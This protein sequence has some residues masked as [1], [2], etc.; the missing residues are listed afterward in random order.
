MIDR[1][2]ILVLGL[3]AS[4]QVFAGSPFYMTIE[5]SYRSD[6]SPE[7]RIDARRD[8]PMI[9]RVLKAEHIDSFL[10]GQFPVS[11]AYEEPK[12]TLNPGHH[13]ARG[14]NRWQWPLEKIRRLFREDFRNQ[15]G[16]VFDRP[17]QPR[18]QKPIAPVPPILT[19]RPPDG[20]TVIRE[21]RLSPAG[22]GEQG[23]ADDPFADLWTRSPQ[24]G[25]G[26]NL[27]TEYDDYGRYQDRTL[28]LE[29]LPPGLYLIQGIQG[30]AEG[31][32]LLQVT[33]L[34]VE[35]LQSP[36]DLIVHAI[37]RQGQPLSGAKVRWRSPQGVWETSHQQTAADG[38]VHIVRQEELPGRLLVEVK[39]GEQTSFIDTDFT[40]QGRP[41]TQIYLLSDRPIYKPGENI[42]FKG[43]L[44]TPPG[45]PQPQG[46]V[47]LSLLNTKGE[48]VSVDAEATI[49][50][51]GSVSGHLDI[52]PSLAPGLYTAQIALGE[53]QF[54]GELRIRDYI[55]PQFYLETVSE[56][57][58]LRS[59]SEFTFSFKAQRYSGGIPKGVRF[60]AYVYRKKYEL[61]EF[62]VDAGQAMA[63]GVDYWG[64]QRSVNP[65]SQPQRLWST[66]DGASNEEEAWQTLNEQGEATLKF[67]LPATSSE[68]DQQEWTYVM[69]IRATDAA[70][71]AAVLNRTYAAPRSLL[72]GRLALNRR[73]AIPGEEAQ[74]L[75]QSLFP[76]GRPAPMG[77]GKLQISLVP[78]EGPIK[79]VDELSV[80]TD[81]K[82]IALITLPKLHQAGLYQVRLS[83]DQLGEEGFTPPF[84]SE[85]QT[86]VI[87]SRKGEAIGAADTLQLLSPSDDVQA[88]QT[89]T[90][91]LILPETWGQKAKG[92]IWMTVA[93][94]RVLEHRALEVKGRSVDLPLT[95][96]VEW[97]TG[98]SLWVSVPMQT[99]SFRH[100]VQKFRLMDPD[101][102]IVLDIKPE[103]SVTAPLRPF[104][105]EVTARDH[106]GRP[107]PQVELSLSVVDRAVYAIQEEIRPSLVDFFY[108]LARLNLAA[109]YSKDLQG[110]GYGDRIRRPTFQ[111]GS[112][113]SSELLKKLSE[114][115]TAAWFPHLVTNAEGKVQARFDLPSNLTEWR[116]TAVAHD[117]TG[118]VGEARAQFMS[119]SDH[120]VTPRSPQIVRAGDRLSL[121]ITL[122]NKGQTPVTLGFELS[123]LTPSLELTPTQASPQP[124]APQQEK[125]EMISLLAKDNLRAGW[126]G[127]SLKTKIDDQ[128]RLPEVYALETREAAI[129]DVITS[130]LRKVGDA[131][132]NLVIPEQARLGQ[133]EVT[134]YQGLSGA[135]LQT[136]ADLVRYPYGCTE[137]L[138]HATLPNLVVLQVLK[139]SGYKVEDLGA[140]RNLYQEAEANFKVGIERILKNQDKSGGMK[141]FASDPEPSLLPTISTY[142]WFHQ[143]R[144]QRP[145]LSPRIEEMA[146]WIR[147]K[148]GVNEGQ[149]IEKGD[150]MLWLEPSQA[151]ELLS[152]WGDKRKQLIDRL[153]SNRQSLNLAELNWAL[154]FSQTTREQ[155]WDKTE[156]RAQIKDFQ[157]LL[158][159]KW[160][161]GRGAYQDAS[162]HF[163]GIP[164]EASVVMAQSLRALYE[165]QSL[166]AGEILD[167]KSMLLEGL[168]NEWGWGSTYST[169]QVMFALLPL[170]RDEMKEL[171]K[172]PASARPIV[173]NAVGET[174][175]NM[176]PF[177]G[178][179]LWKDSV[180]G[181]SIP[182]ATSIRVEGAPSQSML[183]ARLTYTL[184]YKNLVQDSRGIEVTR[185][186]F[187][188]KSQGAEPLPLEGT[189]T[190]RPGEYVISRIDLK[191]DASTLPQG[192]RA[193]QL[194]V[195]R[196]PVPSLGLVEEEDDQVLADA[197]L[198]KEALKFQSHIRDTYRHPEGTERIVQIKGQERL[199]LF[200]VW[201]V[202]YQGQVSLPPAQAFDMYTDAIRARSPSLEVRVE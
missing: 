36:R 31:Q 120:V 121:P 42:A 192:S 68:L 201:R 186:L 114:R 94:D 62:V 196:D 177:I 102:K 96:K 53:S 180:Q 153:H 167:G 38:S 14:I 29:P 27:D 157:E 41:S 112:M 154:I 161:L 81:A 101:R 170:I 163:E 18:L 197:A 140:Y 111:L 113:K 59:G 65:L 54:G 134:A 79:T 138:I 106:Q 137:Q 48:S 19:I 88:G 159:Q 80:T 10:E 166:S 181:T 118:R 168:R 202:G 11:R 195:V 158:K 46:A 155:G 2:L 5:R 98:A 13:L 104:Q 133:L 188:L 76:D 58:A 99:G 26:N 171:R 185:R 187:R 132:L 87:R 141:L 119:R 3:L 150:W 199:S 135:V 198:Q 162:Y 172:T 15:L 45:S 57:G 194:I 73:L 30:Q 147:T 93:N 108:P 110:Y 21:L 151:G 47:R 117:Q 126:N 33:D 60:A 12:A 84:S 146:S 1:I 128:I 145:E 184:A 182:H 77:R 131:E 109:F 91:F 142:M 4:A 22:Q 25:V 52:A 175:G 90:S 183:R 160:L 139:D 72:V 124:L 74:V 149:L 123:G 28:A 95:P 125:V 69:S 55:K 193:S 103:A 191:A 56:S 78:P 71:S 66:L 179:Y 130:P 100:V 39:H 174:L 23:A 9:L 127:L 152:L 67:R 115:D 83:L 200:Q 89:F 51:Q 189:I 7:I 44:H 129:D 16:A 82:G 136:A 105:I 43:I 165:T 190:L 97:G 8:E 85:P 86:L 173:R 37:D 35:V 176:S 6:E 17:L 156:L 116:I 148:L 122:Q 144:D 40:T 50:P 70:G 24:T 32:V 63:A 92:T 61:P 34:Q 178:G 49:T 164:V 20:F 75:V 143:I 169:G 64:L 107:L